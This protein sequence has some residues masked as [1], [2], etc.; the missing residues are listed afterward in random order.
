[1]A[2]RD[3]IYFELGEAGGFAGDET[4]TFFQRGLAASTGRGG[5]KIDFVT[6][7]KWFNIAAVK[8]HGEARRYRTELAVEMSRSEISQAQAEARAYLY[9]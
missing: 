6:A 8:G 9:G 3:S 4:E 1:M 5:V 7:H 2:R